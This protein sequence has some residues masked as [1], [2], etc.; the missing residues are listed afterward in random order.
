LPVAGI[1]LVIV[2]VWLTGGGRLHPI[3]V[4]AANSAILA[5]GLEAEAIMVGPQGSAGL[6]W[7]DTRNRIALLRRMGRDIGVTV[8]EPG[9]IR[10]LD[11]KG[12]P[13]ALTLRFNSLSQAP[14][15]LD[16]ADEA[17]LDKWRKALMLYGELERTANQ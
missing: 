7:L 14:A 9:D 16:F 6:A 15:R 2:L 8:L 3:S 10:G 13:P 5:E 11:L 12:D 17:E 4:A 1:A